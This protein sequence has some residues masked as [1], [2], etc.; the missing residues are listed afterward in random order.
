MGMSMEAYELGF[1]NQKVIVP[2][3]GERVADYVEKYL[4]AHLGLSLGELAFRL[5]ADK[6]DLQRL[7]RDR[8]CGHRLEDC[9]AAYFGR[10]F[11]EAVFGAL[12]GDG[13]SIR[14]KELDRERAEMAA[15]RE[16]LDRERAE[17]CEFRA[18]RAAAVR[19]ASDEGRTAD[20]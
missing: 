5:K 18:R 11:G 7:I 1:T 2:A 15:R 20:V 17:D 14:E 8:S 6:R 3:R 16:R 13:P 9:L 10:D 19:M 4:G 12:W